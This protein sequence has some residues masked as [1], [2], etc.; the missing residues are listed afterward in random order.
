MATENEMI[1]KSEL[2]QLAMNIDSVLFILQDI[3]EDYFYKYNS[4]CKDDNFSILWEFSR[5]RAKISAV[6]NLIDMCNEILKEKNIT[7][8]D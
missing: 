4:H 8:Y 3:T 1:E 7:C 6:N 2:I 5:N